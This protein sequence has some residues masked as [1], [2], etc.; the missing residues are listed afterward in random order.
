M[1]KTIETIKTA[2]ISV[3]I[4]ISLSG[5]AQ[6]QAILIKSDSY[7]T[8]NGTSTLHDWEEKTL[9]FDCDLVLIT[10]NN[11][12]LSIDKGQFSCNVKS[13]E[14][15]HSLMNSK[16]YEALKANAH[17][18][19]K[20]NLVSIEKLISNNGTFSFIATGNVSIAGKIK[21]V[22]IPISGTIQ[23]KTLVLKGTTH[24]KMPDFG[25]VPPE[26]LMGTIKT[27]SDVSVNFLL[28]FQI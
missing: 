1:M 27:G 9:Q 10:T 21:P 11:T 8:I 2:L 6:K 23:N 25:I 13:I 12:I 3:M 28:S 24:I 5:F 4:I 19:L 17:P 18:E 22:S 26:V 20:F 16:T 7:V 15:G 14:S